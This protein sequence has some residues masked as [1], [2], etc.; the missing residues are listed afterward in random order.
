MGPRFLGQVCDLQQFYW[1][2]LDC[3]TLLALYQETSHQ[4]SALL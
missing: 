2:K 4:Y 1:F 3:A